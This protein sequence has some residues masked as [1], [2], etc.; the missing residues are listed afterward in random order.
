MPVHDEAGGELRI[1]IGALGRKENAAL[2]VV[3][4]DVEG[5]RGSAGS[6]GARADL[7]CSEIPSCGEAVVAIGEEERRW[8]EGG[9]QFADACWINDGPKLVEA[10]EAIESFEGWRSSDGWQ[11]DV[12]APEPETA[13]I[14]FAALDGVGAGEDAIGECFF[15]R[16]DG[17]LAAV[18]KAHDTIADM[19]FGVA[20]EAEVLAIEKQRGFGILSEFG[21]RDGRVFAGNVDAGNSGAEG[22]ERQD[23]G[24]LANL[25]RVAGAVR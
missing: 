10:V 4:N 6:Q 7:D 13:G 16:V 17:G 11:G 5:L 23:D 14:G 9:L 18:E 15:V 8:C 21:E 19:F 24:H 25:I 20:G 22:S 3:L 1:E 12:V 2:G